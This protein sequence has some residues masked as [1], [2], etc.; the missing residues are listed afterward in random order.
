MKHK[1]IILSTTNA[2]DG[3]EIESYLGLVT[4]EVIMGANF[5]RDIGAAFRDIVGG[6]AGAYERT[7][8]ESKEQAI[9]ELITQA[10]D[11]G[12][13]AIIGIDLDFETI[14]EKSSILMVSVSGT[15][16]VA[17]RKEQ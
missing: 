6:R 17:R 1:N 15:A 11:M 7:L 5:L 9:E 8:V 16:V 12:A 10:T 3:Y 14:G 2:L 4:S 13:N